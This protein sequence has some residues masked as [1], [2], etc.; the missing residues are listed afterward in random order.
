M[1]IKTTIAAA[2]VTP[3]LLFASGCATEEKPAA[4]KDEAPAAV[5][6]S[7]TAEASA[8]DVVVD[9]ETDASEAADTESDSPATAAVGDTVVVGG[10]DVKVTKV[11]LNANAQIEKANEFNEAPKHQYMLVRYDA[12]YTGTERT[13]DAL[14]DLS[15]TFST[16]DDQVYEDS[17]V[18]TP[19]DAA[20]P[21]GMA[22]TEVRQGG[23]ATVEV[24]FDVPPAAVAGGILSVEGYDEEFNTVYADFV[25]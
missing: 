2:I 6:E 15:W 20:G 19:V 9:E 18:V 7:D 4:V 8:E 25:I 17:S 14:W 10:W 5:E 16:T 1:R 21:N 24:V 23:T 22:V 13:A 3:G 12:T 11:V